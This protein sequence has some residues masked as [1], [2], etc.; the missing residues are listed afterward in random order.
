MVCGGWARLHSCG[1]GC[2]RLVCEADTGWAPTQMLPEG[3]VAAW[4]P[5]E[6]GLHSV[7]NTRVDEVAIDVIS[8]PYHWVLTVYAMASLLRVTQAISLH[9]YS[10]SMLSCC[11]NPVAHCQ[12]LADCITE[13]QRLAIH[14]RSPARRPLY[15]N[16]RS[17]VQV[18]ATA[19]GPC[20]ACVQ[21]HV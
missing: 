21:G 7:A 15:S 11:G 13:R 6:L 3:S 12:R 1:Y 14:I 18:A 10:P 5:D 19:C 4:S 16:F 8:L 9:V 17:L 2:L 20:T